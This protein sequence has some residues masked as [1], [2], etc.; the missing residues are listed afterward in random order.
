MDETMGLIE[1]FKG[2]RIRAA[3]WHRTAN[4][5]LESSKMTGQLS[6]KVG[7]ASL[8]HTATIAFGL[9][10]ILL[11]IIG[12]ASVGSISSALGD[13][14]DLNS[15]VRQQRLLL[16]ARISA[17]EAGDQVKAY[18]LDPNTKT[19]DS[20]RGA[21]EAAAN[22]VEKASRSTLTSEQ[23]EILASALEVV[24][25]SD[26]HF[27][28]I[29]IQQKAIDRIVSKQIYVEGA[30][31]QRELE[32]LANHAA[33]NG[34]META[35][36]AREAG[37]AYSLVRISFERFLANA[38]RENVEAAKQ[39][40][41]RLE[42]VLNQLYEST[43]NP[44]ILSEVDEAIKRLINFD[45]SFKS[46]VKLTNARDARL[47]EILQGNIRKLT[48]AVD[49]VGGQVDSIQGSAANSARLKLGGL[50]MLSLI[51]GGVGMFFVFI[52]G[53]VF[54]K[55]VTAPIIAI[56]AD[57][58]RL[59]KGD[60]TLESRFVSRKDE[61]GEMV[62]A[63]EVFRLN[64][65]E[66]Q[67]LQGEETERLEARN[68]ADEA[69]RDA[70]R[71]ALIERQQAQEEAERV[72][73]E[74]LANLAAKFERHVASAMSTVADAARKIDAGA[75]RAAD[76]V[77]STS[78]IASS[79][80]E[81]AVEASASTATIAAA[82]EEM[83]LSL[84]EVAK[85]VQ[86]S[87]NFASRV[88]DRVG[89][90]DSIVTLLARDAGEIGEVVS[91]VHNIAQQVNLLALNA[92]I[93]ASRAGEAGRGF[94]VVAAEV[95]SL[96][97]QTAAAT[98]QISERVSSI[99]NISRT[100]MQAIHEIGDVIGEMGVLAT[101]VAIA[102]EQQ[103][104]TTAEIARNTTSAATSTSHFTDHLKRVQ[105]GVSTSGDAAEMARTAAAEVSRQTEALQNEIDSFL[106]S[107]R[108][109]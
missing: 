27:S 85:Q 83:S 78:T 91:L 3:D 103:V 88:V 39:Q 73:R 79:I 64:A 72:K 87:S 102:V 51:L 30:A 23:D 26:E 65:I 10:A 12:I 44:T 68:R 16:A 97:Q 84:V 17:I 7:K 9:Q 8:G 55:A 37:A 22:S 93:E 92:T 109:A 2:M 58:Q 56:T 101:S 61:V 52:A 11:I 45:K 4:A 46:V 106:S 75:S 38:S 66:I 77:S 40:S 25:H 59:A 43:E 105:D 1:L 24:G 28:K 20:A 62:Q 96:A 36:K 42:D 89:Q 32:G 19:E 63:M 94:A 82:T 5:R 99:Q 15:V 35:A 33:A 86:E 81:S 41:L 53:V 107:V 71:R 80:T 104:A 54:R 100:A 31:I 69:A 60:L 50:L 29:V 76:A 47:R 67:R 14:N 13:V 48:L 18:A 98:T 95:K 49:K 108:A 6:E 21:L 74:M 70:E 90:T 34:Q 57:M